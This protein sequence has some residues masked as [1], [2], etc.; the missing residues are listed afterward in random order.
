MVIIVRR[1]K[2]SN[3]WRKVPVFEGEHVNIIK[4]AISSQYSIFLD[5]TG[6]VCGCGIA[7]RSGFDERSHIHI[8][9]VRNPDNKIKIVNIVT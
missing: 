9:I 3:S 2:P 4:M 6:I 1:I 5:D 8:N 7:E